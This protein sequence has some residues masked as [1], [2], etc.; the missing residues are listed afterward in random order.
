[1][2]N[3]WKR[4]LDHYCHIIYIIYCLQ[5]YKQLSTASW[6]YEYWESYTHN[7]MKKL[8]YNN[9]ESAFNH[10]DTKIPDF[11]INIPKFSLYTERVLTEG[12]SHWHWGGGG[13]NGV[14]RVLRFVSPVHG[15]HLNL[16]RPL[17]QEQL[18]K[19][20]VRL[21]ANFFVHR[22]T[23]QNIHCILLKTACHCVG[24]VES[25]L[26]LPWCD[27]PDAAKSNFFSVI[28]SYHKHNYS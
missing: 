8:L 10:R 5:S 20:Y 21:A 23:L 3:L 6:Y 17:L 4:Y 24:K 9:F 11:K 15:F 27:V 1:M 13:V 28:N 26:D 2:V 22:L 25:K 7:D 12:G 19:I 18:P 16:A 14:V